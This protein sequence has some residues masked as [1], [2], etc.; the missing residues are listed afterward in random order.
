MG[1]LLL[2]LLTALPD[3]GVNPDAMSPGWALRLRPAGTLVGSYG[4]RLSGQGYVY[5]DPKFE[6]RVAADGTVTFKDKH[7]SVGLSPLDWAKKGRAQPSPARDRDIKESPRRAPWLPPPEATQGP[8]REPEPTEICPRGSSC[9]TPIPMGQNMVAVTGSFDLTD[10]I[11]RALGHEPYA[12]EKAR[13]LSA[14]FEFRMRMASEARQEEMKNALDFM[15][16]HLETLWADTRYSARERRRILYQLWADTDSTPEGNRA[17]KMI[18]LFVHRRLPC[19]SPDAFTS[20][21][22]DDLRKA[23][24]GRPF[25]F[26]EAC[27]KASHSGR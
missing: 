15:P 25:T 6:A 13:F 11:Q 4:L 14:T 18:E 7:G 16:Q 26:A 22:L 27:A 9:Y 19:G 17:A 24:P 10:E 12:R 5:D 1:Y 21:E 2:L 20:A 8:T 3:A 23:H